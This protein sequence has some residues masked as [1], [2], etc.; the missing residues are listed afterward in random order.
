MKPA[1]QRVGEAGTPVVTVDAFSGDVASLVALAASLAPF[2]R[3]DTYY[4]GVRRIL[5]E[6]EPAFAYVARTLEAAAPFIGGAFDAE[7]FDLIEASFSIVTRAP[8]AL[9]DPQR[10][11]H[12]DA[13]DPRHLAI[14]HYLNVPMASGT[15]FYRQ[16]STGI[17]RV[18]DG[19]MGRFVETARAETAATPGGGYINASNG[20]F[21]QIGA[22]E[23]VADRLV[24][25]PGSLL[26]SGIIPP[27]MPLSP[28]PRVGRLT[29]NIFVRCH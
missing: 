24:L 6:E 29:A 22:V 4:P 5:R 23:A 25:Y 11:P 26:H 13:T 18:D 9:S 27:D 21:E 3:A 7:G 10:I 16:R 14:M 20:A 19:N 2:P 28:D 17:E 8:A 15:A 12:F 1:L